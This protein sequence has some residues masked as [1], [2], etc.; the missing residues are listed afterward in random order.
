MGAKKPKRG[1]PAID[2]TAMVD[3]AFLLLTF[4]ILTTTNFRE[5]ANLEVDLP[6]S[7]S[8]KELPTDQGNM[9]IYLSDTG[10]VYIGFTD[11][12]TRGRVLSQIIESENLQGELS[13]EGYNYFTS[14]ENIGT[15]LNELLYFLNLENEEKKIFNQ[16]GVPYIE[17]DSLGL[18]NEL[19]TWITQ[20]RI[21]DPKM[22]FAIRGDGGAPFESAE[23]VLT[24]LRELKILRMS[25]ITNMEDPPAE[26]V[27]M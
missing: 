13:E 26:G 17:D 6:S 5:D 22:R 23:E 21:A 11:I 20:G 12:D 4:F 19:K 1:A 9:I 7:T 3:V 18:R 2:M 24:T 14:V 15:P 27:G 16:K 10:N 8:I 25:I